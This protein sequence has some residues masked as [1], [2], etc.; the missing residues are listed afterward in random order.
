MVSNTYQELV[1]QAVENKE[2]HYIYNSTREHAKI[3]IKEML[4]SAK[5]SIKIYANGN[6][7]ELYKECVTELRNEGKIN[8]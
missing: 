4:A 5:K 3:V 1:H 2:P 6:D 8:W 7:F